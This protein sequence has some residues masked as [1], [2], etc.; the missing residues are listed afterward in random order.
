MQYASFLKILLGFLFVL[1]CI[2]FIHFGKHCFGFWKEIVVLS[3]RRLV[4]LGI[5]Y[6]VHLNILKDRDEYS[7]KCRKGSTARVRISVL[8]SG[9]LRALLS[10]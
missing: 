5:K 1:D 3:Q 6:I 7:M 4:S 10:N 8:A 9:S 2:S